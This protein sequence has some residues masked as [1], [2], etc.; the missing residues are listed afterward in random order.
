M[1]RIE[2]KKMKPWQIIGIILIGA[3]I[4]TG[5]LRSALLVRTNYPQRVSSIRVLKKYVKLNTVA[6][7]DISY[8][9]DK[10]NKQGLVTLNRPKDNALIDQIVIELNKLWVEKKEHSGSRRDSLRV[11]LSDKTEIPINSIGF[12]NQKSFVSDFLRSK[13]F[14]STM[15]KVIRQKPGR[16]V[17]MN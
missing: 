14:G 8:S 2:V 1:V 4:I 9:L 10:G 13:T 5:L 3:F 7:I 6:R 17:E 16:I 15:R 11:Y 12:N